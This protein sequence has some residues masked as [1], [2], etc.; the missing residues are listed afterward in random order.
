MTRRVTDGDS[1]DSPEATSGSRLQG[2]VLLALV[3]QRITEKA[4]S[5]LGLLRHNAVAECP[6]LRVARDVDVGDLSLG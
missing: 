6:H 1:S 2:A 4:E 3:L 5:V